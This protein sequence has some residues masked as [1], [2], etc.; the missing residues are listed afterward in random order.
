MQVCGEVV[1][2]AFWNIVLCDFFDCIDYVLFFGLG[3][4][5]YVESFTFRVKRWK[6]GQVAG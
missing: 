5:T 1:D 4:S 6:S 2:H 3:D